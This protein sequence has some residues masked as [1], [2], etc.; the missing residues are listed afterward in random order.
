MTGS[1][2]IDQMVEAAIWL[3]VQ[4]DR[5]GAED[6]LAQ[7]LRIDPTHE[8]ARQAMKSA[9]APTSPGALAPQPPVPNA[10]VPLIPPGLMRVAPV[11]PASTPL[12]PLPAL[13]RDVPP[14]L[15]RRNTLPGTGAPYELPSTDLPFVS[16]PSAIASKREERTDRHLALVVEDTPTSTPPP[17]APVVA[18]GAALAKSWSLEVLTGPHVGTSLPVSKRPMLIGKGLGVLDVEEDLFMSSAH[19]S[20]FQRGGELWISDGGSASGTWVSIDA[21]VRLQPGESFSV[22]LQRLKYLGPLDTAPAEQP[23]P[24]GAPRPAAS[25]RL[26]HVLVGGRAARTWV[27]R[28]VVTIGRE[29]TLV[30]F[31]EDDAIALVHAELRPAGN[32]LEIVDKSA[33]A[34]TF[35]MLPPSGERKVPEGTRVRLGST[36]FRITSR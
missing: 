17:L 12:E 20:F 15:M 7:V 10:T 35:A 5:A 24:Y 22:G 27:L 32:A 6:L 25:W 31:P 8:R 18:R 2:S 23:W 16:T 13:Q 4:G 33:R 21:P 14:G 3:M 29:G 34:G 28:G 11:D 36:V 26:E 1:R 9:G 19:A 30:R